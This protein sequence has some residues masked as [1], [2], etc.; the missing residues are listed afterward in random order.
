ME[1]FNG[2]SLEAHRIASI[3]QIENLMALHSYYHAANM[4]S[5]E[6]SDIWSREQ[7]EETSWQQNFGFWKSMP[8]MS[9][10]YGEGHWDTGLALREQIIEARPELKDDLMQPDMDVRRLVEVPVHT[11]TTSIIEVAEDGMSAKGL[12]YTPGYALRRNYLQDTASACWMWEK[13]GADFVWENGEWKFLHIQIGMDIM[14]NYGE[15][16]AEPKPMGGPGGPGG[17]GPA[18]PPPEEKK[19]EKKEVPVGKDG[20]KLKVAPS[21]GGGMACPPDGPGKYSIYSRTRVPS[22]YPKIP[23]P[24]TTLS[25]TFSY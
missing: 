7:P 22:E 16:W 3:P 24:Y 11:L 4:N 5:N 2:L 14:A 15:S 17:P 23:E 18:G 9:V 10:Y 6:L 8:H 12:W 1:L 21:M 13:Y 25:E 20:K 19:P